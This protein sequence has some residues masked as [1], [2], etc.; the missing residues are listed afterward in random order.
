MPGTP[1]DTQRPPEVNVGAQGC[2]GRGVQS[3]FWS[4]GSPLQFLVSRESLVSW[5][6]KQSTRGRVYYGGL[7]VFGGI[8]A[9]LLVVAVWGRWTE[10]TVLFIVGTAAFTF[11]FWAAIWTDI[12]EG[13][14][15]EAVE[16]EVD[17]LAGLLDQSQRAS[18]Q[19]HATLS[20]TPTP[21][22]RERERTEGGV[23]PSQ[24]RP[25]GGDRDSDGTIEGAEESDDD[26]A[27]R[28][29]EQVGRTIGVATR[30]TRWEKAQPFVAAIIA[31]GAVVLVGAL[32]FAKSP[33]PDCAAYA[34]V[35]LEI[36]DSAASTEGA[37]AAANALTWDSLDDSCGSPT[38]FLTN[39]GR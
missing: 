21:D 22:I 18:A 1:R 34:T 39:L 37:V 15:D 32:S 10:A 30:R 14:R 11:F 35:L 9:V 19:A 17:A 3:F 38:E 29:A 26:L 24:E 12:S 4:V 2:R 8:L 23:W 16:A 13:Q 20:A 6:M 31:A 25:E 27:D 36:N 28:I 33:T 7:G 5:P